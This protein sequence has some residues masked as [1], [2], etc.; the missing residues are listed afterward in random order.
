ML[1]LD[2]FLFFNNADIFFRFFTN[3][4][5]AQLRQS[6]ITYNWSS[7]Q[8]MTFQ[9]STTKWSNFT[10]NRSSKMDGFQQL[11]CKLLQK[12]SD[13]NVSLHLGCQSDVR[14]LD[15]SNIDANRWYQMLPTKF[16]NLSHNLNCVKI[17]WSLYFI[18]T[19]PNLFGCYYY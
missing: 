5:R 8:T 6:H 17:R 10:P 2:P 19:C 3:E 15:R 1:N 7:W 16:N 14:F 11:V 13:V 12:L 4:F 18:L 9:R